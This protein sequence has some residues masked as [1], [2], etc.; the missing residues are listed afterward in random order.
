MY[1]TFKTAVFA[2]AFA[3]ATFSAPAMARH[4]DGDPPRMGLVLTDNSP[5]AI[6][7]IDRDKREHKPGTGFL[8]PTRSRAVPACI[9]GQRTNC[10]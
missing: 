10:Q 5:P 6:P 7:F 2:L 4:E 8:L 3:S 9:G 1:V